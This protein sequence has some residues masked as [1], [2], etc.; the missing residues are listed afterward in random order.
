VYSKGIEPVEATGHL[1]PELLAEFEAN[2]KRPLQTRMRYAFLRTYKPVLD[3]ARYRSFDTMEAYRRWCNEKLPEWLG[4]HTEASLTWRRGFELNETEDE[5]IR[6]GK[7]FIQLK[8]GPFDLD[9]IFAPDGIER[10]EDAWARRI[11][12]EGF[13]VCHL[14]DIIASKRAANRKKDKE[15]LGRL[16]AFREYWRNARS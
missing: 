4:Y 1:T 3:E 13:P 8:N 12:V 11:I 14:D 16:E 15:S 10:F 2:A 7:D 5:E 6:R 9:L